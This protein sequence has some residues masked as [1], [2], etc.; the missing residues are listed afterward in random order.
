[1]SAPPRPPRS[2][3]E[4]REAAF[5]TQRDEAARLSRHLSTARVVCF[6]LIIA[7]GL[8]AEA[9]PGRLPVVAT[10][11]A[12]AVFVA[13]VLWQAR[14]RR[15]EQWLD[16]LAAVNR[17][18][19]HRLDRAWDS[20]PVRRRP[21]ASPAPAYAADLDLYGRAS[22]RQL[23]GATATI[24]GELTLAHWLLA[25]S[26]AAAIR[27]RQDAARA[28]VPR[29][30]FRDALAAHARLSRP[31][32]P[33]AL[34]RFLRWA[35]TPSPPR[36]TALWLARII[37]IVT[38]VLGGLAAADVLPW[39]LPLASVLAASV[40]TFGKVGRAA[41][42]EM[43]AAFGREEIFRVYPELL[44]LVESEAAHS[45]RLAALHDTLTALGLPATGW[46][47]R[48]SRLAHLAGLRSGGMLYLPVQ[49]LT[50]WDFHVLSRLHGWRDAA[51]PRVRAWLEVLGEAEALAAI[52]TLAHDH[53]DWTWPH[54]AE[55][56]VFAARAVG[57]PLIAED[58]RVHNDVRV[59]PPGSFLLVTGSNMSGKST[60]LRAIGVNTVLAMAGAPACA[61]ELDIPV[62][63]LRTG[64]H[65]QDSLADGVSF[66]MAQLQ[67]V[68][69]IVAAADHARQGGIPVLYL[70]DEILQ[71]TNTAERRIAATRVIRH[72]LDAGAIG[73]VT[74]HDLE[75]ADSPELKGE[76]EPVH[77]R[78]TVRAEG[79]GAA[80]TFDYLLRPGI[81][82]STNALR[83]MEIVGLTV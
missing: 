75:L 14:V 76:F 33:D 8:W 48:L 35:E 24:A 10:V 37:P 36:A 6:V 69:E 83:L 34:E 7:A 43:T 61:R 11:L 68:K 52:A 21:E 26:P 47:Q 2:T 15:R 22:L 25:P 72:L 16:A 9:T 70:L 71:G 29:N 49:L 67:R 62:V 73:A 12:L 20:L 50:L 82:T 57:H 45:P 4:A 77:L 42:A 18:G 80:L 27:E 55:E 74:T 65:V 51:G 54:I 56:H 60:L 44:A 19:L 59:G 79:D 32:G 63:D 40:L 23:L 39:S 13:L 41:R 5:A 58:R 1:M 17:E 31:P 38:L 28:L 81:A 3:Y 30:E 64:I 78:E 53:P 46:M 66:F